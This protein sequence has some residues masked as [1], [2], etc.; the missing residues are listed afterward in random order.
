MKEIIVYFIQVGKR[1][2]SGN[3]NVQYSFASKSCEDQAAV[4]NHFA[5]K[6]LGFDIDVSVV[7]DVINEDIKPIN[8]DF[9]GSCSE[10]SEITGLKREIEALKTS[11]KTSFLS[12]EISFYDLP[13]E[14]KEAI[15]TNNENY[16]NVLREE[17]R[18]KEL[19]TDILT[20]KHS[21]ICSNIRIIKPALFNE[22]PSYIY[23][24]VVLAGSLIEEIT[25]NHE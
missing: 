8:K 14:I 24:E 9:F 16:K 1:T 20:E 15:K 18:I 25:E 10:S 11:K 21:N 23:Y 12:K 13:S 5:N 6:Y 17:K 2:R 3:L 19:I 7:K 4:R 22:I